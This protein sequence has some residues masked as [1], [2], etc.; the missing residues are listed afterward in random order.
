MN[1]RSSKSLPIVSFAPLTSPLARAHAHILFASALHT[2][3]DAA[4]VGHC[5]GGGEGKEAQEGEEAKKE[6]LLAGATAS[7]WHPP[8]A[9]QMFANA[10]CTRSPI[11]AKL[12]LI[13]RHFT[14]VLRS[15]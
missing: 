6:G 3:G 14:I 4:G 10:I 2:A 15:C 1:Q 8:L 7:H 5:C 9:I 12:L 13:L 11:T